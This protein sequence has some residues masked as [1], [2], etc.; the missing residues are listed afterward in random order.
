MLQG[1][2]D[3]F[4]I[5]RPEA[6][7]ALAMLPE[8]D[9]RFDAL[10][11]PRHLPVIAALA[12]HLPALSIV[13]DHAAKPF[14]AKGV[15]EPWEATWRA[16]QRDRTSGPSFPAWSPRPVRL[17]AGGP[18]TLCSAPPRSFGPR[19]LMFGS[20]WPVVDLDASY[21]AWWASAQTLMAGLD[22]TGRRDVFGANAAR[23]YGIAN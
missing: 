15:I 21:A 13:V 7:R 1:I 17:V 3:T 14:I 5:F 11:Q 18:E 2:E 19:R 23:F 12:D 9:L 10:V 20:D 4:D 8:L 22:E 16:R 6:I